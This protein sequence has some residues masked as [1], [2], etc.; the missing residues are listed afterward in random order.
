MVNNQ[1]GDRERRQRISLSAQL[2]REQV[3]ASESER[4]LKKIR[5]L[6]K[7]EETI[8]ELRRVRFGRSRLGRGLKLGRRVFR[9]TA[10]PASRGLFQFAGRAGT[11]LLEEQ[12]RA[13]PRRKR[14]RDNGG[15]SGFIGG[16]D[17]NFR[18]A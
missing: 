9:K 16:F 6:E 5:E 11:K 13:K 8:R 7:A 2:A 17:P 1:N 14:R 18:F 3:K 4:M 12:R 10:A 15:D